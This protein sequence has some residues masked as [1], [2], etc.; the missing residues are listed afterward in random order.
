MPSSLCLARDCFVALVCKQSEHKVRRRNILSTVLQHY[1]PHAH[2]GNAHRFFF[3]GWNGTSFF[4][5]MVGQRRPCITSH[6]I[7]WIFSLHW[8]N[9]KLSH[10]HMHA[11]SAIN[12]RAIIKQV[13]LHMKAAGTNGVTRSFRKKRPPNQNGE[14]LCLWKSAP[15]PTLLFRSVISRQTASN[16][17]WAVKVY[18][19]ACP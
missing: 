6:N 10:F 8:N 2:G 14:R 15:L 17:C 12:V 18:R 16:Y 11:Q 7:A 3:Q 5:S 1:H 19:L 9:Q 13:T 4:I